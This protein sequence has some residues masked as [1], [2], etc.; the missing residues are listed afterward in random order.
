MVLPGRIGITFREIS[1]IIFININ[2]LFIARFS[3][4]M[5][6]G[7]KAKLSE[8]GGSAGKTGSAETGQ[9]INGEKVVHAWFAG[10]FPRVQPKYAMAVF[11]ENGKGGGKNAAPIFADIAEQVMR[12]RW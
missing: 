11:I 2:C 8:Y 12:G 7:V 6:T 4:I 10:Y 5:S 1:F 9:Y 3:N